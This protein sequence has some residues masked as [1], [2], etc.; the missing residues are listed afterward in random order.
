MENTD[1]TEGDMELGF[2]DDNIIAPQNEEQISLDIDGNG[3][4]TALTDGI[5]IM[6]YM[7]GFRGDA[8]TKDAIGEDITR[9]S[10]DLITNYLDAAGLSMTVKLL[11]ILL[12]MLI[13]AT[14]IASLL[15]IPAN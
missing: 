14:S 9:S 11:V 15:M 4:I 3:A 2:G 5:Q 1:K 12:A 8:L 13:Q 10:A 7:F 6:R